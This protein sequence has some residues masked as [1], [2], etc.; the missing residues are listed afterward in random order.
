MKEIGKTPTPKKKP[1]KAVKGMKTPVRAG[2]DEDFVD[3]SKNQ[4]LH[5]KKQARRVISQVC[6]ANMPDEK[7]VRQRELKRLRD[8]KNGRRNM[9]LTQNWR[10]KWRE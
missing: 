7:K 1:A 9:E 10:W 5:T 2:K 8:Q 3:P 4:E 6:H